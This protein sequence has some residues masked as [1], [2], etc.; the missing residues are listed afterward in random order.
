MPQAW[1]S[2]TDRARREQREEIRLR[3]GDQINADYN[4]SK[5][6]LK[7]RGITGLPEQLLESDFDNISEM[8]RQR[9]FDPNKYKDEA[10][11]WREFASNSPMD[12]AVLKHDEEWLTQFERAYR[13][14]DT[15]TIGERL[16]SHGRDIMRTTDP[17]SNS[18]NSSWAQNKMLMIGARQQRDG[19]Q[20][21]DEEK[22]AELRKYQVS[23]DF[24]AEWSS[25]IV[26]LT[27]QSANMIV[28]SQKRLERGLQFG[29]T[30]AAMGGYY[31]SI[32]GTVILP[33]GGTAIGTAG[34]AIGGFGIGFAVGSV[35]GGYEIGAELGRGEAYLEYRD[36]GFNEQDAAWA[37]E[38][39]GSV[40]GLLEATLG[41]VFF[42]KLPG[43]R[44]LTGKGSAEI[45]KQ[46]LGRESFRQVAGRAA[47]DYGAGVT[48]EIVT[49]ILQEASLITMGEILKGQHPGVAEDLTGAEISSRI[50]DVAV[51]TLKATFLI[52]GAGPGQRL[53]MDGRRA[54]NAENF[55]T[56]LRDMAEGVQK[57]DLPKSLPDHMKRF[58]EMVSE[59]GELKEIGMPVQAFVEYSLA[60]G[61]DPDVLAQEL[62]VEN[63]E[64]ARM[65][66]GDVQIPIIEFAKKIAAK[67]E[68]FN[69]MLPNLRPHEDAF[70]YN[71][72]QEYVKNR[73]EV[74]SILESGAAQIRTTEEDA[75]IEQIVQDIQ[76]QLMTTGYD[77][78]S[79]GQLGQLLRG[80]GVMAKNEGL[81]P[82]ELF[83]QVFGGVKRTTE[84]AHTRGEDINLTIDPLLNRLRN[85]DF[86][87]QRDMFGPSLMDFIVAS[88][89]INVGDSELVAMD[90]EISA[91]ELGVS[92]AKLNRWKTEGKELSHIAEI[93]AEAGYIVAADENLLVE[94]IREETAGRPVQGTRDSGDTSMRD[95]SVTLDELSDILEEASIDLDTMT[96]AEIRNALTER[97]TLAQIDSKDLRS[98]TELVL[99]QIGVTETLF[100]DSTP[101]RGKSNVD[102]TLGRAAAMLPIVDETQDFGDLT[103]SD[104]V[105][106]QETGKRA[107]RTIKVETEFRRSVKRKNLLKRL[108][109]CVNA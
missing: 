23:H 25:P 63:L 5:E 33:G 26:W 48:G 105:L 50:V 88:G 18:W 11:A 85:N 90:F 102:A 91:Q 28:S 76:G 98:L 65:G 44:Q 22:L 64:L 21:G 7:L 1:E 75:D 58:V 36:M 47:F 52:A 60:Q 109:D 68:V 69:Q 78:V 66:D 73:D 83:E 92:K 61:I 72:A 4:R 9:E 94:A 77:E 3:V 13:E 45:V 87:S 70:T 74:M 2:V 8:V 106:I 103:I 19:E 12:L 41:Q 31:G 95:L 99:Q 82:K 46:L 32:G 15:T 34:G 100:A 97:V 10:P 107:T 108:L 39:S 38:I 84:A 42:D 96:N 16:F 40:S 71:E 56:V 81:D 101:F 86:P 20:P 89:G 43:V 59:G 24:G 51:E 54:R 55:S 62:G 80:I 14:L 67:Q 37:A 29:F 6:I 93:A 53:F 17:I 35:T 57:A 104:R 27:K 30:G 79:A 49:E